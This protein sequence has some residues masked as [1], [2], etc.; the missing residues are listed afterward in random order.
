MRKRRLIFKIC[1]TIS[2]QP[3]IRGFSN[4]IVARLIRLRRITQLKFQHFGGISEILNFVA[5][6]LAGHE[7][8]SLAQKI[9]K[10]SLGLPPIVLSTP[11]AGRVQLASSPV[12]SQVQDSLIELSSLFAALFTSS[13]SNLYVSFGSKSYALTDNTDLSLIIQKQKP[14]SHIK[15]HHLEVLD[16]LASDMHNQLDLSLFYNEVIALFEVLEEDT[17]QFIMKAAY[18]KLQTCMIGVDFE[19]TKRMQ[20]YPY[21][22]FSCCWSASLRSKL[23]SLFDLLPEYVAFR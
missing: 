23:Y 14:L 10:D 3:I 5:R 8:S 4:Y 6:E 17:L 12:S 18:Q 7:S 1:V 16:L 21:E 15:A 2:D 22:K 20:Q 9:R 19:V 13:K 11:V